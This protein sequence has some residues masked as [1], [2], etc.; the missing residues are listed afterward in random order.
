M[1]NSLN[2]TNKKIRFSLDPA[3][4]TLTSEDARSY[5]SRIGFATTALMVINIGVQLLLSLLLAALAPTLYGNEIVQNLF[6]FIPMYLVALPVFLS[7]LRPLPSASPLKTPIN[8]R[9]WFGGLCVSVAIMT[10][11]NSLSQSVI[12]WFDMFLGRSL[13]NPV[14]TATVGTTWWVNLIFVALLAPILEEILFRKILCRYLLPLGEGYAIVLSATIF[15]LAHG[16]FFQFF[17]A[18]GLGCIFAFIYIK[19]GKLI[20]TILYHIVINLLG[21]VLAP[22]IIE[23]LDV[24]ALLPLLEEL[25]ASATPDLSLLDPY[26]TPLALLLAYEFFMYGAAIAGAILFFRARK[27]MS[28]DAGLLPPPRK[29]RIGNIFLNTGV[30]AALTVFAGIFLLSLLP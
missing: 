5:F 23:Q 12:L 25:M 22:W 18:F 8:G 6:S 1:V 30:A 27:R 4:G 9:T 24:E 10:V 29:G 26:A 3:T 13:E 14:E 19:T 16:N 21:G 15:G 7:I 28:L 17:Y 2:N 11:G 20:Y